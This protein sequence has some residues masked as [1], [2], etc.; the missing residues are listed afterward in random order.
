VG[1]ERV[2]ATDVYD[3]ALECAR[4]LGAARTYDG[5][6]TPA[7]ALA[8]DVLGWTDAR[9]V[10]AVFDTTGQLEL[11]QDALRMLAPGGTLMLMA[12]AADGL[13]L[14]TAGMA[15]ERVVTTSSN[16]TPEEFE[17]GLCLLA[18]GRVSVRPMITHSFDLSEAERAF[19]VAASKQETGAI[20]VII[21]PR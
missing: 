3:A 17:R 4:E 8:S 12:G 21:R 18:E 15:G 5:R 16:N 19:A 6:E 10:E 9:G 14:S 7:Q 13:A 11:Q 20:K 2:V 1:A